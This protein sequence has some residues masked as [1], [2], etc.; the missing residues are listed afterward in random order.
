MRHPGRAFRRGELLEAVWGWTFGDQSTVTVHVRRLREKIERGPG[1]ADA[2]RHRV[3]RRVPVRAGA[4]DVT[5]L[6]DRGAPRWSARCSSRSRV[7]WCCGCCAAGRSWRTSAC[8]SSVTVLA[9]L[10]GVIAVARAC[11]SPHH[12]LRVLL[13]VISVAGA[14]SLAIGVVARPP[15]GRRRDVGGRGPGHAN[16]T[17]EA[18]R[19]D[20][21]AWVSHDLR[22]PLAGLRAMAE[23]LG[24]RG[25]GRPGDGRRLPPPDPGRDRP[26]GRTGRRPVRAVPDQRRRAAADA[27]ERCRSATSSPTRSPRPHRWPPPDGIR[28]VAAE[29]GWPVVR[30]SEPELSRIVANLLR[31]AIRYTP[32]DGTVT[33]TG[34]RDDDGG[35]FA[36]TDACG[37]IPETDL[38]RVFD[39]AFRGEAARTP[40][41]ARR[42]RRRRRRARAGHRPRPGRGAPRRGRGRA[43][44]APA[45]GSWS[46]CR[47]GLVVA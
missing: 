18:N 37:G 39:V 41:R 8:C 44:S 27:G 9:V 40:P 31:N 10:A 20:L 17:L 15:A 19:R 33:V 35:W 43:T 38:P 22:T 34:G 4:R 36:V 11:S 3:G 30:A 45:A 24:G 46:G 7:P 2:D 1:R 6:D 26:D 29:S 28:L 13:I 42:P 14:V 47:C 16:G 23:A 32:S 5:L 25:G 12:D 21:V